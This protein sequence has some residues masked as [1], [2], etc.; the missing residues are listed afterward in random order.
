MSNTKNEKLKEVPDVTKVP[1][2][3]AV[4]LTTLLIKHYDFR[5]GIFDLLLEFQ[6]GIG[7]VPTN[8]KNINAPGVMVAVTGFGLAPASVKG[9]TTV[10]AREVNPGKTRSKNKVK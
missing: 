6:I 5:E 9:P 1:T 7:A 8:A 10:D 2:L 4:D 3:S